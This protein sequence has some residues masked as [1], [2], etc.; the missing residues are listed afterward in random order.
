VPPAASRDPLLE[1]GQ[2]TKPHG[3][4]GEVVVHLWTNQPGRLDPGSVLSSASGELAVVR[5][6]PHKGHYLVVF[7][8]VDDRESADAL[9]GTVL[10]AHAESVP[11]ALW[12]HELVGAQVVSTAGQVLGTVT[13]VEANPASDLLVLDGG[14]LIPLRFVVENQPGATVTVDIPD[15]LLD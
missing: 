12:V 9:R 7:A 4:T 3:L 1:V 14:G 13:S 5:S 6:R 10:S 15:G 2:I 8:G 11:G